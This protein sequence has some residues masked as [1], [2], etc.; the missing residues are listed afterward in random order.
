MNNIIIKNGNEDL[1][2]ST[3]LRYVDFNS[4]TYKNNKNY[5]D[6]LITLTKS[7]NAYK[8]KFKRV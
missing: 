8:T 3:N 5:K 6:L 7:Y 4:S 2:F 1:Y